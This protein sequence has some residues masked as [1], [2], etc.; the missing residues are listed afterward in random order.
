MA[1]KPLPLAAKN[2]AL[3]DGVKINRSIIEDMMTENVFQQQNRLNSLSQFGGIEFE[4]KW[5][6]AKGGPIDHPAYT[7]LASA[8]LNKWKGDRPRD[9]PYI[10]FGVE[11]IEDMESLG[12]IIEDGKWKSGYPIDEMLS[13]QQAF[14]NSSIYR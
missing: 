13:K 5:P 8:D 3:R 10:P 12:Y 6:R 4:H 9:I 7:G 2:E 11:T 14:K 1:V